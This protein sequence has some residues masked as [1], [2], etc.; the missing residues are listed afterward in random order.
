MCNFQPNRGKN[1]II[2]A[3]QSKKKTRKE[4]KKR[5]NIEQGDNY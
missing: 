3:N 1:G 5:R 2:K 4:I